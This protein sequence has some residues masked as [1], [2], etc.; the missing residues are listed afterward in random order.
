MQSVKSLNDLVTKQEHTQAGFLW[1]AQ[2]KIARSG[3]YCALADYFLNKARSGQVRS[4]HDV[5]ADPYLERFMIAACMLSEKSLNYLSASDQIAQLVDFSQINNQSY[6]DELVRRYFL[7]FGD[8]L[9]GAMRNAVG[10]V[11]QTKLDEAI[12]KRLASLGK[13]PMRIMNTTRTKASAIVWADR[14]VIFDMIPK[15]IRKSVDIIVV[16]KKNTEVVENLT[17]VKCM[18]ERIDDYMCAGELKSGID[19]AGADEHWKTAKSALDRISTSF[20]G[21]G[22]PTP[23]L[24]FIGAAIES[25]MAAEIFELLQSGWLAG[26]ANLNNEAQFNEVVDLIIA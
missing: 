18:L 9:G 24:V 21:F 10:S 17:H 4:I 20:A 2:Q 11:G 7:T 14:V 12:F 25:A 26:A 16:R 23:K 22:K 8:S 3:E 13:N 5:H 6:V 19:P 15:F 1:Q